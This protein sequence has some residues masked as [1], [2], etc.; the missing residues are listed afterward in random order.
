MYDRS[1]LHV[2]RRAAVCVYRLFR[3][4]EGWIGTV[5]FFSGFS[6][7]VA[8]DRSTSSMRRCRPPFRDERKKGGKARGPVELPI[9]RSIQ[10]VACEQPPLSGLQDTAFSRRRR[11]SPCYPRTEKA[12]ASRR[13]I[14]RAG[15]AARR[16]SRDDV[17]APTRIRCSCDSVQQMCRRVGEFG[18][19]Y[20]K[21]RLTN[22]FVD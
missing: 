21:W 5:S 10:A 3:Q 20:L 4:W 13:P 19:L 12:R 6:K 22:Y 16:V 11:A 15:R 18:A 17:W 1:S 7:S 14:G 2:R 9:R 8:T